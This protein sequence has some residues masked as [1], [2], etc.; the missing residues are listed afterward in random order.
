VPETTDEALMEQYLKGDAKAFEA[1]LR[2]HERA[3]YHFLF[4][5]VRHKQTSEDLLQDTFLRVVHH[6]KD[7]QGRSKFTTWVFTIARNLCLDHSRRQKFR[8]HA[9]LDAPLSDDKDSASR[10]DFVP[11]R[12]ASPQEE[13]SAKELMARLDKAMLT[14]SEDQKEVF[15]LREKSGLPFKEIAEIVGCPENTVKTRMR[16]ALEKLQ[17]ALETER[18]ELAKVAG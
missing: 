13:L 9:S 16:H 1:L 10:V 6:A 11:S 12:E 7:F 3:V 8:K 14:L 2:R 4:R 15:L 17:K 18:E 5:M